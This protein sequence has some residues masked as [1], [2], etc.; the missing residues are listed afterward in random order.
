LEAASVDGD[1]LIELR[2]VLLVE[3]EYFLA[4]DLEE[5]LTGAGFA[6]DVVSSGEEALPLF[7][8]GATLTAR[9]L[10]MFAYKAV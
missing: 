9:W 7:I 6:N 5:A 1:D 2:S 4:A 10:P 8:G 3:D